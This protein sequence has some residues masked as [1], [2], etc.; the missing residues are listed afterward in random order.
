MKPLGFT[1]TEMRD[2]LDSLE[3]LAG[4]GAPEKRRTAAAHY[5]QECRSK[6]DES[7]AKLRKHLAYAEELSGR[8]SVR[9]DEAAFCA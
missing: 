2:L 1:L 4:D 6:V 3:V 7:A 8:L 9:T 5:L